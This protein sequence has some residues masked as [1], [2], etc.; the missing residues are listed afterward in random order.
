[1]RYCD[2]VMKGGITSGIVYPAA[3]SEI[4]KRFIFRNVGGTSAGAI[5][6]VITAAAEFRRANG[7][8]SGFDIV[9]A[10]PD[11]LERDRLL[12]RLFHPNPSTRALYQTV[13]ALAGRQK[14]V[15]SWLGRLIYLI[16][17]YPLAS[18]IGVLPGLLL[19]AAAIVLHSGVAAI[20][21]SVIVMCTGI[22]IADVLEFTWDLLRRLP[23]N[24]FGLI[25]GME[26]SGNDPVLTQWLYEKIQMVAG[27]GADDP[28]LTFSMLWHGI[29][30]APLDLRQ[31]PDAPFE[32]VVNLEM[33]TTNVTLGRPYRWPTHTDEFYFSRDELEDFFPK[34][35]VDWMVE[36]SRKANPKDADQIERHNVHAAQ[37][38]FPMPHAG[39]LPVIVATRM[40]LAF[41]I[42]LS[43]VPLYSVDY[44]DPENQGKL[45]KLERC[46]FSDGGLS[47]NFPIAL[48]DAP[49]PRWPTFAINLQQFPAWR[50]PS[51]NE[52]DNIYMART[53]AAGRLPVW[54]RFTGVVGLFAAIFNTMQN[55]RDTTL[56]PLPGYRDRIVTIFMSKD[57]GGLNLDMPADVLRRLRARGAAAGQ[58]IAARFDQPSPN[59]PAPDVPHM[60]WDNHR[61]ERLLTT[62]GALTAYLTHFARG[63]KTPQPGDTSFERFIAQTEPGLIKPAQEVYEVA[64]EVQG[65]GPLKA[66]IPKPLPELHIAPQLDT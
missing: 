36:R 61:R 31:I 47:S 66:R 35:V 22:S 2:I 12:F 39:D 46:W 42:L 52:A 51:G 57:E 49:L 60:N 21:A 65:E 33:I 9:G 62:M 53:N 38:L 24:Y 56:T 29:K 18:F 40:S 26:Q 6:A 4:A 14:I 58:L 23:P 16:G 32:P 27:L 64:E 59:L 63:Y 30:K 48:F 54:M 1:M 25:T 5:A 41:P 15:P 55:W 37:G 20:V 10:L 11:E 13:L 44:S 8:A 3:V 34:T 7:D 17:A 50:S 45:P 43:A 19:L 28:P